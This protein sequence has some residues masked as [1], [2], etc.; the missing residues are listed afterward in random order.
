MRS[1]IASA[2]NQFARLPAAGSEL[3][4][5]EISVVVVGGTAVARAAIAATKT[6]PIVLRLAPILSMHG[7]V[8]SLA[9][10]GGNV[11][12]VTHPDQ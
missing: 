9:R 4:G 7:L 12:G 5:G 2:E 1:L 3:V 6:I 10:P 11:T 8:L